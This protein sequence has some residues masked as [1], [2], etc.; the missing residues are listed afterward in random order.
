MN[1]IRSF[2]A[3]A[4]VGFL[5]VSLGSPIVTAAQQT[6]ADAE[7]DPVL[8]AMLEE[9]DRSMSQL[10]LPGFAKPFFIQ[11]RIE[12]VQDYSTKAEY[13]A[14]EGAQRAHERVARVTVRVGDYKTD[15]SGGRGDGSLELAALEDDPIAT[16]L[17]AMVGNGLCVQKRAG[18]LCAKA[19]SAQTGPDASAGRRLQP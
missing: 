5:A 2:A 11:Y 7:K 19:G 6:R 1:F 15:S 13:G 12:E 3:L 16:P 18:G 4:A 17:R 9:L 8:K 14:S 10:Q